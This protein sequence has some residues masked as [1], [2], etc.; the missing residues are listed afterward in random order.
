MKKLWK[1]QIW[2]ELY[3]IVTSYLLFGGLLPRPPPEGLL[4]VDGAFGGGGGLLVEE[5]FDLD[6]VLLLII[7]PR[8]QS[9]PVST[10]LSPVLPVS[11]RY[12]FL[13]P[14]PPS[15]VGNDWI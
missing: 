10:R 12:G 11:H 1:Y 13:L 4:V 3:T 8:V 6:M 15:M 2:R 5:P 7:N 14:V 9:S